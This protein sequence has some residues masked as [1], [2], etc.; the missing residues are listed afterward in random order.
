MNAAM[1]ERDER[2]VMVENAGN[3]L[4]ATVMSFGLLLDVMYRSWVRH[5]S[6]W[7]L[8]ALVIGGGLVATVYRGANH[9]LGR[10]W[11]T[12]T[13]MVMVIAAVIAVLVVLSKVVLKW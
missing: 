6:P 13:T 8:F 9:T 2:A 5:E 7:D 1:V 4:A 3:R 10:Q 12:S 11:A